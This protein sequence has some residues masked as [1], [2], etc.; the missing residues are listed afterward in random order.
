MPEAAA[1]QEAVNASSQLLDYGVLGLF[2]LLFIIA[3]GA[4]WR[5]AKNERTEML[6]KLEAAQKE[7]RDDMKATQTQLLDIVKQSNHALGDVAGALDRNREATAELRATFKEFGEE[8]R[9]LGDEMRQRPRRG[10]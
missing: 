1:A 2:A 8:L 4:L 3:I 5:D 9:T 6:T 10:A 7:H